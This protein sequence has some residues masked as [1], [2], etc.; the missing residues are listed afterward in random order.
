MERRTVIVFAR[1]PKDG[2]TKTRLLTHFSVK[3]VTELYAC[4]VKDVLSLVRRVDCEQR[5]LFYAGSGNGIPFLRKNS[6]GFTLRRQ[7]G[8]DLGERMHRGFCFAWSKGATKTLIIGTDCLSI[9]PDDMDQAFGKL[10]RNDVVLGPSRDGGYYLIGLN[11]PESQ[12]FERIPWSSEQVCSLTQQKAEALGQKVG[13][14]APK[15]DI[16]TFDVLKRVSRHKSFY[17]TAPHTHKI[18]GSLKQ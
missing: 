6:K 13:L 8:C 10:H 4:F 17:A 3:A 16:D 11:I 1:E 14:L 12:L 7:A 18:L 15:E 2:K 9:T 5:Y